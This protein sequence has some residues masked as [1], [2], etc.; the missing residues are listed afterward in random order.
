MLPQGGTMDIG[1]K[2]YNPIDLTWYNINDEDPL[3]LHDIAKSPM[4][5]NKN[6]LIK[7]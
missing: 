5:F 4:P 3:I 6:L 7:F 1:C 2:N